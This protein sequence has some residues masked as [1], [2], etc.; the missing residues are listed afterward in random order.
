[1]VGVSWE[2]LYRD[3][4]DRIRAQVRATVPEESRLLVISRGD[5]ALLRLERRVAEH[6]PQTP[7]GLYAGH[8]PADGEEAVAHLRELREGGAE[9]LVIPA[10]ARWWLEHYAELEAALAS[11]GELLPSDPETALIY[12]LTRREI[13]SEERAELEAARVAPAVGSLLRALLPE[14]AGVVLIGLGA[15]AVELGN[16]PCRRLL[17]YPVEAA[18]E[19]A[20]AECAAGARF[21]ALIQPD[22]PG[23]ALDGSLRPA[24]AESM[25]VVCR[26]RLAEVFEVQDG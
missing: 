22:E 24:F 23:E 16:R 18:I 11:D 15:E 2:R 14:R 25:R 3:Q 21:V 13:G 10:T 26:Q 5:E 9:Y 4:V 20:R 12:S 8:Y 1:V 6:F 7:T 17:P 19:Q